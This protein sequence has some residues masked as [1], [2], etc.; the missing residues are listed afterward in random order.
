VFSSTFD[1]DLHAEHDWLAVS[2][3]SAQQSR[4]QIPRR[5]KFADV[6]RTIKVNKLLYGLRF[7]FFFPSLIKFR[8]ISCRVS[9]KTQACHVAGF[10]SL[11]MDGGNSHQGRQVTKRCRNR[12]CRVRLVDGGGETCSVQCSVLQ[13]DLLPRPLLLQHLSSD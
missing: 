1:G 2:T 11:R 10:R 9:K 13:N 8:Q 4:V 3:D 7:R 5:H 6:W 12:N